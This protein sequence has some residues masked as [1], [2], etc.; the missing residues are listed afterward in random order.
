[1]SP[2]SPPAKSKP[3]YFLLISSIYAK[4]S[5][6]KTGGFCVDN[7]KARSKS[8]KTCLFRKLQNIIRRALQHFTKFF[9][10]INRNA[11]VVLQIKNRSGIDAVFCNQRICCDLFL[12]HRPPQRAIIN[13]T[14]TSSHDICLIIV[15]KEILEY[16]EKCKYNIGIK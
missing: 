5:R 3:I 12:F 11:F 7:K 6:V 16:T 13:Q 9:Q 10:C 4:T 2:C 15:G 14:G 8:S 1:M